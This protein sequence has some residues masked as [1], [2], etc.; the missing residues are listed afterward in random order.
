MS[1]RQGLTLRSWLGGI[2]LIAGLVLCTAQA[3][4]QGE[5]TRNYRMLFDAR[6]VPSERVAHVKIVLGTGA[7]YVG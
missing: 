4:A 7:R 3:G 5:G 6:I 1:G 2:T